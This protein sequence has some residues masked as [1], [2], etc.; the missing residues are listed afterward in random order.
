M[1]KRIIG[2]ILALS[3]AFSGAVAVQAHTTSPHMHNSSHGIVGDGGGWYHS[4][5][6][7]ACA[8]S[9]QHEGWKRTVHRHYTYLAEKRAFVFKHSTESFQVC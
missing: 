1:K 6:P 7:Y 4:S 5:V 2:A 3:L 8:T 9:G